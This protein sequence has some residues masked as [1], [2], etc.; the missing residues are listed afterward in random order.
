MASLQI[1][2]MPQEVY[3][4][5]AERAARERR[6]LA[7]QAITELAQVPELMRRQRKLQ[8]IAEIRE[9]VA[10]YGTRQYTLDPVDA[11]REDRDR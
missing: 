3:D 5:L 7:Q 10:K 6:S 8:V 9:R 1:R 2:D 11:I 4:A